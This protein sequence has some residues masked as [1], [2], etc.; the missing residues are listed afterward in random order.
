MRSLT[1]AEAAER[2][3]HLTVLS[4]DVNLD[5]TGGADTFRSTVVIRFRATPGVST[6]VEVKPARLRA[7]RLNGDDLDPAALDGNRYPLSALAAENTLL[8]E[9]DMAYSNTG[10]GLHQF[11]DPADGRTYLYAMSFLDEVQRIF[12]AFDQP[13]LKAPVRLTVTAPPEWTVA[14]NAPLARRSADGRWEFASTPPLATYTI[15]LIAGPYAARHADHRGIPLTLYC[16]QSLAEYLDADADE[17]FAITR[18]CLDRYEEMFGTPYPFGKYDQAFVPE[19]TPGAME[20]PGLVTI[21]DEHIFRSAVTE[22]QREL[23]AVTI[24]HEMAHMWFGDLVTMRWWDDLWLN[25]AF[26]EYLG[27]RV[28]AEVTRYDRTWVSFCASRKAGGYAA[29]QRPSTHPVA[30]EAVA[31]TAQALVN[32]DGISYVKGAS[33]LRQLAAW[34]GDEAFLAGL[35][36]YIATHQFGNAT[37][38]DLLAAMSAASGRDLS[39]WADVWLRRAQVNTVRVV[40]EVDSAGRYAQVA[41]EQTAPPEHPVLRP[42]RIGLGLYDRAGDAT[43]RRDLL[44]VDLDP[45]VDHGRTLVDDLR[46]KPAA[47]LLLPN[48]GDLAYAKVRLDS[49]SAAAV[50]ELL[51]GLADPLA[52]AVLWAAMIDAVRDAERP[53][54]DLV[55]LIRAALPSE[56]DSVLVESVLTQA[57]PI[58]DRYLEPSARVSALDHLAVACQRRLDTAPPGSSLQLAAARG[59]IAASRDTELLRAWLAGRGVPPGL[60]VDA[61]VRWA[62]LHRLVVL[63][64][65]DAAAIEAEYDRDRSAT[66]AEWAAR[67]RASLPDAEAKDRAWR[68]IVEDTTMSNR[69]ATA[70]ADGFWQPEQLALTQPYVSRY[71]AE[72]PAAATRRTPWVAER[73]AALAFPRYAVDP[74]TSQAAAALLARDDLTA[75][76]R[77]AV[78]DA[79]DD[80]RRALAA[81]ERTQDG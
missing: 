38:R 51:P 70:T 73:I 72:M 11:V 76:L 68:V 75:G 32:F 53:V 62:T 29:D 15:S 45:A 22:A 46:G 63:G 59:L 37:L 78:T 13:D 54:A 18:A 50:P 7:V 4:Y 9:A 35:R 74:A 67:C 2:A 27:V 17:I 79:A 66:G 47:A 26:A 71:F 41:L 5:L 69:L 16:R 65:A 24:A 48:D 60:S 36:A 61:D 44:M 80:L 77:R 52:R 31:D 20:N 30:P 64:A 6:F 81:R 55:A 33:V 56:S 21:R 57:R 14:A 49:A 58:V 23:R 43:T 8:V 19:F 12:A 25:E 28:T 10:V 34:L 3:A 40:A 1:R 39:G 42:Q